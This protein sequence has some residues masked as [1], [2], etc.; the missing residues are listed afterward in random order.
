MLNMGK[1]V[2]IVDLAKELIRLSGYEVNK[3]IEIV[4]TKLRPGEKLF[5]ELF[6]DGEEYENT[7]HEKLLIVKNASQIIPENLGAKVEVL[8]GAAGKN[9]G[10]LMKFLL[11]QLVVGYRP[12]YLADTLKNDSFPGTSLIQFKPQEI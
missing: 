10:N 8:L 6:V 5:E 9:D 11:E 4:F 3:D 7:E 2:K 1:P 12:E